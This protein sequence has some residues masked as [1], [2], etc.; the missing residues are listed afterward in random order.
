MS[1]NAHA[2]MGTPANEYLGPG[3]IYFDYGEATEAVIGATKGGGEFNDNAEFRHR[4][5]DG[6]LGPVKGAI[7]LIK[8]TPVLSIKALKINKTNL[9]KYFAGM[10]LDDTDGTYSKLT[11]TVD[12]D[13]SYI[14]NV[15]FIG[16]NRS[17]LDIVIILYDAIGLSPL[18][19]AFTKDEEIVQELELTATFDPETFDRDDEDTYP[20]QIW[21]QKA[22]DTTA[23][24]VSSV[25]PADTTTDVAITTD[26]VWTFDEA[27]KKATVTS[28]NF[29]VK[30]A[31]GTAVAGT[32]SISSDQ[33]EITFEPD[34]DLANDTEYIAVATKG[35][36]DLAGNSLAAESWTN[37]TTVA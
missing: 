16:Q 20:Y 35:V 26:V 37:F 36:K 27:I 3:A 8:M 33:T 9:Q 1:S 21:L 32:L 25:S 24:T 19:T 4:E 15:A 18:M 5:A 11:R 22:S 6:D 14:T 30:K 10:S 28:A 12:I 7:D 17:G 2:P 29:F 13:D 34:D 23:P 31:D